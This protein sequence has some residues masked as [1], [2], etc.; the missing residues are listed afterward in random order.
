MDLLF[1]L[2]QPRSSR[3]FFATACFGTA[4]VRCRALPHSLGTTPRPSFP[5]LNL[6]N[7]R[8][9]RNHGRLPSS[10]CIESARTHRARVCALPLRASD[11]TLRLLITYAHVPIWITSGFVLAD[12]SDTI[13]EW[14]LRPVSLPVEIQSFRVFRNIICQCHRQEMVPHG[15]YSRS[16]FASLLTESLRLRGQ[17]T[18]T[19]PWSS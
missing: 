11:T 2:L 12:D 4:T 9:R 16:T 5:R 15:P 19:A 3:S 18:R 6:H 10:R 17:L 14:V 7:D 1:Q 13:R 8:V